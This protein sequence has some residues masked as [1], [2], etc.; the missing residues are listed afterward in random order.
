MS[1]SGTEL[2]GIGITAFSPNKGLSER[3]FVPPDTGT[4]FLLANELMEEEL[5]FV[6]NGLLLLDD[7]T[8]RQS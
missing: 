3:S 6:P 8:G 5:V 4:F 1:T 7:G 2:M